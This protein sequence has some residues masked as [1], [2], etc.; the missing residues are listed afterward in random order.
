MPS[1]SI[2]SWYRSCQEMST[3]WWAYPTLTGQGH[4][5]P[6]SYPHSA[7]T[8]HIARRLHLSRHTPFTPLISYATYT[9]H[10]ARR[11]HLSY[12][13]TATFL[14]STHCVHL[15]RNTPS[16]SFTSHAVYT[17]HVTHRLHL[18]RHTMIETETT[19]DSFCYWPFRQK[20][21]PK[22]AMSYADKAV[23]LHPS[24][25][26]QLLTRGTLLHSMGRDVQ[27]LSDLTV[28]CHMTL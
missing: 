23:S 28:S 1:V 9:S 12:H 22:K 21:E 26:I 15:S 11:L 13:T 4:C 17:S 2:R 5:L 16:T 20:C 10:V 27:A 3:L 18:S 19:P 8:S 6:L 14:A 25:K 7:Y 24:G